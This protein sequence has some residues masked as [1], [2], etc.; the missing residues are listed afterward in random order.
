[1]TL[2]EWVDYRLR[3]GDDLVGLYK[4]VEFTRTMYE[5]S[6][7][8]MEG[9]DTVF[10]GNVNKDIDGDI[11]TLYYHLETRPEL[12]YVIIPLSFEEIHDTIRKLK[13]LVEL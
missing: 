1:M 10:V 9:D 13:K 3:L 7:A 6:Q 5:V 11:N 8:T 12:D 2:E 4:T